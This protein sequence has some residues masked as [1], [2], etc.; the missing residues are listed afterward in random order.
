MTTSIQ[1]W[2]SRWRSPGAPAHDLGDPRIARSTLDATLEFIGCVYGTQLAV[3]ELDAAN[4]RR[5]AAAAVT[6]EAA[7]DSLKAAAKDVAADACLA[8]MDRLPFAVA[9]TDAEARVLLANAAAVRAIHERSTVSAPGGILGGIDQVVTERLHGVIARTCAAGG[10]LDEPLNVIPLRGDAAWPHL[11]VMAIECGSDPTCAAVI[12]PDRERLNGAAQMVAAL[13]ALTPAQVRLAML[14]LEGH[15]LAEAARVLDVR[16][17]TAL[18]T[19]KCVR[20]KLRARSD[21]ECLR[22]LRAA[23]VAVNVG[24]PR[25][26]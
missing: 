5:T 9:I 22:L 8:L 1:G 24:A 23:L 3:L 15:T 14:I 26:P 11:I 7:I 19:W 17:R 6:G 21:H 4:R 12:F 18:E 10:A 20:S 25:Q 16:N 13:Y 2:F